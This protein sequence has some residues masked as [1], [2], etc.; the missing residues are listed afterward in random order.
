M[1][2]STLVSEILL[3]PLKGPPSKTY[4]E[5]DGTKPH[6]HK[7]Q[8]VKVPEVADFQND[9]Q[10]QGFML[11][12][13]NKLDICRKKKKLF[14]I[15]SSSSPHAV[16][17]ILTYY[18]IIQWTASFISKWL[19]KACQTYRHEYIKN[20]SWTTH[21]LTYSSLN[22]KYAKT[23][24]VLEGRHRNHRKTYGSKTK[25]RHTLSI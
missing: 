8:D 6:T 18:F 23:Q 4:S 1:L 9:F 13:W 3:C 24:P 10:L 11:E 17:E 12:T 7:T 16:S 19:L 15:R 25:T 22:S 20:F 14:W 5:N 2:L 21:I